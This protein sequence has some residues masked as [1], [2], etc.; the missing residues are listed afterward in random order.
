M[1]ITGFQLIL[2]LLMSLLMN[3]DFFGFITSIGIK[4][5]IV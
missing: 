5:I 3:Y 4:N 2:Q 1:Y